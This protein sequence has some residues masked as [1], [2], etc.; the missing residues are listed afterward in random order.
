MM[1][2]VGLSKMTTVG[3]N[4]TITVGN[5]FTVKVGASILVMKSDGTITWNGKTIDLVA[6]EHMGLESERIDIN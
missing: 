2:N 5:T 4:Y 6:S 3:M 1:T